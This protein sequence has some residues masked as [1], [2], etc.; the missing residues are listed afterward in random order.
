M[1]PASINETIKLDYYVE[2]AIRRRWLIIIPFCLSMILGIYLA[3]TLPRVYESETLILVEPQK[4]PASYVRPLTS[5]DVDSRIS[6]ISQQIMSRTN[7]EKIIDEFRLFTGPEFEGM[8]LEDKL[9]LLMKRINVNVTRGRGGSDAFKITYKGTDPQKVMQITNTL[10][11]YFIEQNL[12]IREAQA[13]GTSDFL[14]DQLVSTRK[15]LEKMEE[16]LKEYRTKHMGELPEQLDTNLRILE[17]LQMQLSDKMESLRNAKDR[18]AMIGRTIL[19]PQAGQQ[20]QGDVPEDFQTLEELKIQLANLQGR[21]TERHPDVV[22]LKKKIKHLEEDLKTRKKEGTTPEGEGRGADESIA[23]EADMISFQ[24]ASV[25]KEIRDLQKD[26]TQIKAQIRAYQM[27]VDTTPKREQ[28]L[29]D[30]Q[31]DY[32]NLQEAYSSLLNRKLEA[33]IAVNM[34]KKQKG[35]KFRIIDPA[36]LPEKPVSPNLKRLFFLALIAGLGT[37]LGIVL[38]M[39]YLD[40]SFKRV[41]DIES[42]LGLS[43]LATISPVYHGKDRFLQRING[44]ATIFSLLLS[45]SLLAGFA[46]LSFKGLEGTRQLLGRFIEL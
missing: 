19:I 45:L 35:E 31:R 15:K 10:A 26:I 27:R 8:Y 7:L 17:R 2:L 12:K 40:T 41:D 14:E 43:I 23:P 5:I 32:R 3:I 30:L 25:K 21:Y 1:T 46:V 18:L 34:E 37:G 16:S 44:M 38:L 28:E 29:M 4:V 11:A 22:R 36:R 24:R 39:D 9:E 42:E 20:A 6:T 33:E 13:I